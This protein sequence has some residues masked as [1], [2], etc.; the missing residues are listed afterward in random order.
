[1]SVLRERERERMKV[2]EPSITWVLRK[3]KGKRGDWDWGV[4][5]DLKGRGVN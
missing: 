3:D 4:S 1:M 5:N 2:V